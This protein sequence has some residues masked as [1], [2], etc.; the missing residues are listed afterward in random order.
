MNT[1]PVWLRG[2]RLGLLGLV[3]LLLAAAYHFGVFDHVAEPRLLTRSM[4]DMGQWRYLVFVL[5]YT[6]LEPFGAKREC[7][8]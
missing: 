7:G 8:A 1:A 4:L 3:L 2:A 5:A 6:A